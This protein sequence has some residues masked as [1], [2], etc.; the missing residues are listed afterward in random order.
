[1][2][3]YTPMAIANNVTTCENADDKKRNSKSRP[4][5][6]SSPSSK[7]FKPDMPEPKFMF[8]FKSMS[9][10]FGDD[11]ESNSEGDGT[12]LVPDNADCPGVNCDHEYDTAFLPV[13]PFNVDD[14]QSITLQ[15]LIDMGAAYHCKCQ[16]HMANICL[17][18]MANMRSALVRLNDM[19]GMASIKQTFVEQIVYFLV[20][21][22]PN[23]AELLHTLVTGCPGIGKTHV[24]EILANIYTSMGYLTSTTIKRVSIKDLKGK[25]V[26]HTAH[27]TQKAIDDAMGGVLLIDEAY[28]LASADKID[29]FSKE[30]IDILNKNLTERAGKFVCI[31]AGYEQQ[32]QD[33]IFAH[34]PGM[35]SRF[36][37]KFNV[38]PYDHTELQKIFAIKLHQENWSYHTDVTSGAIQKF[39]L[40]HHAKFK[41]YGRDMETLLFHVKLAHANRIL[42]RDSGKTAVTMHDMRQGMVKFLANC[43]STN[44]INAT[45]MYL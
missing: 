40:Q 1:M 21:A 28:S 23:G 16:T 33:C 24:I 44:T 25:Y 17:K 20:D 37:F 6:E 26:G 31:I 9:P 4:S 22:T 45:H 18:K 30:I 13:I 43:P 29:S 41:Y 3:S 12:P 36:R 39:F 42:F 15:H 14:V 7:R 35:A 5:R 10:E 34:N 11:G 38:L 19:V 32:I 27:L 8:F 2:H